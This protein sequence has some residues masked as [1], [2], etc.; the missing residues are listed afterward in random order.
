MLMG[1]G[2]EMYQ[3]RYPVKYITFNDSLQLQ[4]A[5]IEQSHKN[6]RARKRQMLEMF[7]SEFP[8]A[9]T[10]QLDLLRKEVYPDVYIVSWDRF[11]VT[12]LTP[13]DPNSN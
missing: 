6:L 8:F 7:R 10:D 13:I 2:M 5:S 9:T 1:Q 3:T 11:N 4:G 12:C